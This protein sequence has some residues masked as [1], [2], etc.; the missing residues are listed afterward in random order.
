MLQ[1][2]GVGRT[3]S[4]E[5]PWVGQG[6]RETGGE[7][8]LGVGFGTEGTVSQKW[9]PSPQLTEFAAWEL[10]LQSVLGVDAPF[11]FSVM[12][13]GL[14]HAHHLLHSSSGKLHQASLA[15]RQPGGMR[16]WE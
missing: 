7:G 11:S 13:N 10:W 5:L 15:S 8:T 14:P 16:L 2:S 6:Q 1:V 4:L 9:G 3:E 12:G